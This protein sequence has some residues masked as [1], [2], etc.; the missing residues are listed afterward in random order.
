MLRKLLT[1]T[2]FVAI[3]AVS[4]YAQSASETGENIPEV[5]EI[6]PGEVAL[7]NFQR[8]LNTFSTVQQRVAALE[9][10]CSGRQI[11]CAAAYNATLRSIARTELAGDALVTAVALAAES[12]IRGARSGNDAVA[13]I[14]TTL[15]VA[16][17]AMEVAS[18][19]SDV[20]P[21]AITTLV[22]S[23]VEDAVNS[24]SEFAAASEEAQR[25][26]NLSAGELAVGVIQSSAAA[27]IDAISTPVIATAIQ[28][29]ATVSNDAAQI[30]AINTVATQVSQSGFAENNVSQ[31]EVVTLLASAS[32]S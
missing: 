17:S 4:A 19:I 10:F 1:S 24:I 11:E 27:G 16:R 29:A 6:D 30:A 18:E 3:T 20:T 13:S 8:S 31:I 28:T 22:T 2:A 12:A 25:V 9:T 23:V 32:P 7:S 15:A 14:R 21:D 26:A 5:E